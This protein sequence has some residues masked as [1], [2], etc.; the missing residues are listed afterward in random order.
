MAV[1]AFAAAGA[2]IAPAG[3]AAIGW[4]IGALVGQALFPTKLPDQNVEGP[5]LSDLRV[6]TS[7]YGQMVPIVGGTVRIAG[8][9]IWAKPVREVTKTQSQNVGG[10]GKG[11][12]GGQTVNQT[13]Y[14]YFADFAVLLCEGPD[15]KSV[16]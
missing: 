2:L 3:Y 15:R 7:A 10:G 13:T 14:S 4:S 1:L 12:G 16:V 11:G 8:N 5:R 9:L 6:Q